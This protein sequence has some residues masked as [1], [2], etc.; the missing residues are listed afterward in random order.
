MKN[1]N[2]FTLLE[3]IITVCVLAVIL[4][5]AVPLVQNA[6]GSSKESTYKMIE[7]NLKDG[8][9]LYLT[10]FPGTLAWS[11]ESDGNTESTCIT[12]NQIKERGFFTGELVDPRDNINISNDKVIKVFDNLNF[13][14]EYLKDN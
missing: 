8:A 9:R 2:G 10:E 4:L 13:L 12:L 6:I 11:L 7:T 1:K 5:I 14:A 3:L